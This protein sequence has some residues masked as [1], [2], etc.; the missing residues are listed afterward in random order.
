MIVLLDMDGVLADFEEGHN[1]MFP[2]L[3]PTGERDTWDILDTAPEEARQHILEGWHSPGFFR[4]L[5]P[6]EGAIEGTKALLRKHDVFICTAPLM[7]H[8]TCAEEK[9]AWIKEYFGA[10][11]TR[12]TIISADKTLIRGNYLID[13]RTTMDTLAV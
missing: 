1:R 10:D 11:L 2:H 3:K 13:D 12:R 8:A 9:I 6:I 5:K 4:G 7:H